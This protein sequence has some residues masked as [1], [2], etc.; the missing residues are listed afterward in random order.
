VIEPENGA[1]VEVLL[2]EAEEDSSEPH[3]NRNVGRWEPLPS[4]DNEDLTADT[5]E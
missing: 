3:R 5:S 1:L 2:F 4:N